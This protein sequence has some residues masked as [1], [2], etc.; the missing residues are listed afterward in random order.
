M[1]DDALVS[2]LRTRLG[3]RSCLTDPDLRAGYETDWTRRFSGT[4]RAVVRPGNVGEVADALRL[5]SEAGAGVV[6]QGGNT[7]LVGGSVPRGGEVVLSLRRLDDV[8]SV[9]AEAGEVTCGAGATLAGVQDA[10]RA[11][12]WEVGVDL[13]AR[14]TAT[15]GGMLATNA[16][17][18]NVLRHGPMR[19]Q[20]IGFEAVLAD[21][22]VLR[23]LPGMVKD[24]TGY[25]LGGLLAGSEG[26]LA[27]I[28]RVR[29]RL[30]TRLVHRAVAVAG[31][32]SADA[33]VHAG[34]RLRRGLGSIVALELFSDAGLELVMRHASVAP[35]FAER[36]PF[37]L[38]VEAGSDEA[39]PTDELAAAL[40]TLD[41]GE[42]A[43]MANDAAG[44]RRL[45]E[46]RERHTES[47]NAEG[48]PHKLDVSVPLARFAELAER[49]SEAVRAVEGDARTIVYGHLGDG[50]LHVNILGPAPDDEAVDDAVLGLVLELGGSVSAEHGIGVAKVAWLV[51]DRGREAVAAMRALKSAWDPNGILN[52][53]VIFDSLKS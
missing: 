20:L 9:D 46:L 23:R 24:N 45:W 48:V 51:R 25:D 43:A 26:T 30:V 28:T 21:G 17:G 35:P 52:P 36:R 39:D 22:T 18:A 40:E 2:A 5:C 50:N 33:A 42:A 31:F 38:L 11:A 10:A 13:A 37:Y 12:G 6:P 29:L 44:R 34:S 49:A 16:G 7:G 3:D 41:V 1:T 15:I 4:A 8:E 27:V 53:G 14:D 32:P 47:I 19:R